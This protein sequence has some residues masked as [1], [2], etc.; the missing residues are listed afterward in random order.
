MA[1]ST[2]SAIAPTN[3]PS[4]SRGDHWRVPQTDADLPS[5]FSILPIDPPPPSLRTGG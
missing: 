2:L 1:I 4:T 3:T 5:V